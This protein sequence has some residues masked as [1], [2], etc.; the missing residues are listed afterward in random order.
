MKLDIKKAY[1]TVD[2]NFLKQALVNLNFP[3]HFIQFIIQCLI[4]AK[5][6]LMV[7]GRP[8]GFCS[9]K[10]GLRQGDPMSPYLFVIVMEYF[11]RLMSTLPQN[12]QFSFHTK[13]KEMQL[14]R[15]FF[16]DDIMM[17]C[18]ADKQS[19]LILKSLVEQFGTVSGLNINLQKSHIFFCGVDENTKSYLLQQLG[20]TEG[21]LPI[22][23]LGLPLISSKLTFMD[24]KPIIDKIQKKI[25]TWSA[26]LLTYA[27]RVL[28]VKFVLFH[29]QVFW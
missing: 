1:D 16:A 5:Y 17:F 25:T 22:R 3:S 20:F 27:G 6:S 29:F 9:S 21:T 24:C 28:L 8:R 12:A 10:R 26:K 19:P 14:S 18:R 11:S 7:N 15:L 13:C 23:Y 2:W 4:T